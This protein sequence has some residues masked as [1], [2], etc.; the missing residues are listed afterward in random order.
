M[1]LTE[2]LYTALQGFRARV[3]IMVYVANYNRSQLLLAIL[4][5]IIS[6][7]LRIGILFK[8]KK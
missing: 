5:M 6:V 2:H 4:C 1:K 3:I 7:L 8:I